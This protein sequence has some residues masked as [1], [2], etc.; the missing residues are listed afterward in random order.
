MVQRLSLHQ[1]SVEAAGKADRVWVVKIQHATRRVGCAD[2]KPACQIGRGL[3]G[4]SPGGSCDVQLEPLP[5]NI[6]ELSRTVESTINKA[7]ELVTLP[8]ELLTTTL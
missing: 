5:V 1:H 8:S 2:E 4:I 7:F 3:K 6:P